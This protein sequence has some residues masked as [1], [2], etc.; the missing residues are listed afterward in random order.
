MS[1]RTVSDQ[2]ISDKEMT[3]AEMN[4]KK[5]EEEGKNEYVDK[6]DN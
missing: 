5:L 4:G 6:P 3:M 1:S 2:P